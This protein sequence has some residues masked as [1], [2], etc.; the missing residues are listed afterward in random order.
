MYTD[1]DL[2]LM[3][4]IS[5]LSLSTEARLMALTGMLISLFHKSGVI[6]NISAARECYNK[7]WSQ[8]CKTVSHALDNKT[9]PT[10]FDDFLKENGISTGSEFDE[11]V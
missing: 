5:T 11:C 4:E 3:I 7:V 8:E 1:A 10:N 6:K 9:L 2:K